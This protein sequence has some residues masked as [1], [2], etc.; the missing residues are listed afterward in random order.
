MTSYG[1]TKMGASSA[2]SSL[3]WTYARW[4][5]VEVVF[6]SYRY[7]EKC[8]STHGDLQPHRAHGISALGT[9]QL[10]NENGDFRSMVIFGGFW[11]VLP[12][13]GGAVEK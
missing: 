9:T 1:S 13:V 8:D 5:P 4:N 10:V 7:S 2:I 6:S 3:V 11:V 12:A